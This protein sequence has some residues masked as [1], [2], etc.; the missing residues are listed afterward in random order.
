MTS[1]TEQQE[2]AMKIWVIISFIINVR[3]E[4]KRLNMYSIRSIKKVSQRALVEEIPAC[5]VWDVSISTV[6]R[7]IE[8]SFYIPKVGTNT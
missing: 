2:R 6:T 5:L 3:R 1:E 8:K 7:G 4:I